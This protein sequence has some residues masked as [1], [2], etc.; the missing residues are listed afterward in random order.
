M[1]GYEQT[2]QVWFENGEWTGMTLGEFIRLMVDG[3][4]TDVVLVRVQNKTPALDKNGAFRLTLELELVPNG[5]VV[6][7]M[8]EKGIELTQ[9]NLSTMIRHGIIS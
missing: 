9:D 2:P 6:E 8:Y 4:L 7:R 5:Y 3:G 1:S